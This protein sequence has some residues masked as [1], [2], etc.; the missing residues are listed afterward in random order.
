MSFSIYDHK[1]ECFNTPFFQPAE[2]LASRMFM[3]LVHDGNSTVCKHP[4]DFTLYKVGTFNDNSG[5]LE[6]EATPKFIIKATDL[7]KPKET[8]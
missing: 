2:G 1:A 6:S 3:D 7:L 8:A 4:E 5:K